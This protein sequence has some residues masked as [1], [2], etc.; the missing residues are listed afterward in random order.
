M[1]VL[2][3]H[4]HIHRAC[5]VRSL[6]EEEQYLTETHSYE[7]GNCVYYQLIPQKIPSI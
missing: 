2:Y 5:W 3:T 6:D 1:H 7:M 4:I